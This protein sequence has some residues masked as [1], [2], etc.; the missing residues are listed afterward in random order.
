M[1]YLK[2]LVPKGMK[3]VGIKHGRNVGLALHDE[4][5][6]PVACEAQRWSPHMTD[7]LLE[8]LNGGLIAGTVRS[9]TSKC[10][11]RP[12]HFQRQTGLTAPA[13]A[14]QTA[15]QDHQKEQREARGHCSIA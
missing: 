2:H 13:S 14:T 9:S 8:Q 15:Q 3:I 10:A 11:Q 5:V 12:C 6:T 7:I 1:Q 4:S